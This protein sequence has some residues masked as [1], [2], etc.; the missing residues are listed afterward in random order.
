VTA[1][2]RI[3]HGYVRPRPDGSRARCGGVGAG[4]PDCKREHDEMRMEDEAR[5]RGR[6]ILRAHAV[7]EA[8]IVMRVIESETTSAEEKRELARQWRGKWKALE[9]A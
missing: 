3:G 2:P 7:G 4:C 5:R 1:P 8:F 6:A 9:T